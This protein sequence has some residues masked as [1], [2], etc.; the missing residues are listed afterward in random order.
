MADLDSPPMPSTFSCYKNPEDGGAG[1]Q[2]LKQTE[3]TSRV[4]STSIEAHEP[5]I[6]PTMA[7]KSSINWIF[8][9]MH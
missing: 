7:A 8:K 3:R 2:T 5:G 4:P 6:Q 1:Q 9:C